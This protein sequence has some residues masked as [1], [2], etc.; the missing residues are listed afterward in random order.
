MLNHASRS[1]L[2]TVF[3]ILIVAVAA[4]TTHGDSVRLRDGSVIHGKIKGTKDGKVSVDTSFAG[5]VSLKPDM[6]LMV[7]SDSD[8]HIALQSG[9]VVRGKM[10]S[11]NSG[12]RIQSDQGSID[13]THDQIIAV[14]LPGQKNPLAPP[15]DGDKR[16]WKY[17]AHLNIAGKTG[18]SE[19]IST[20]G[21][22]KAILESSEDKLLLYMRGESTKNNGTKTTEEIFGGIDYESSFSERH[23][24]YTRIE[25]EVDDIEQIELR[26]TAAAGYGHFHIKR[27][28]RTLRSRVGLQFRHESF[29]KGNSESSPGLDLGLFHMVKATEYGKLTSEIVYTPSFRDFGNYRAYHESSWD[30]PLLKSNKWFLRTGVSNEYNSMSAKNADRLDTTYFTRLLLQWE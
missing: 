25:L 19:E 6:I 15:D 4:A 27:D 28:N 29:E 21:G 1:P 3:T 23:S 10:I 17:E 8:L 7:E 18:N 2:S 9:N 20:G 14:W 22:A 16:K 30:F 24:W 13:A 11:D 5:V 26:T 12:R